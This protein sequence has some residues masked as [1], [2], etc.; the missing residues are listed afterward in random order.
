[1]LPLGDGCLDDGV[2]LP[3]EGPSRGMFNEL[4]GSFGL[5]M[6]RLLTKDV[7]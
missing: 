7:G 3:E 2:L 4:E 5:L 6:V 1:V